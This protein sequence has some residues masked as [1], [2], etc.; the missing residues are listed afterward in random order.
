MFG[1][2]WRIATYGVIVLPL[3]QSA[4]GSLVF[5]VAIYKGTCQLNQLYMF[6]PFVLGLSLLLRYMW[7]C[8]L[9][10][11]LMFRRLVWAQSQAWHWVVESTF[12]S[13]KYYSVPKRLIHWLPIIN[14]RHPFGLFHIYICLRVVAC[15]N[16]FT[17]T[18]PHVYTAPGGP[19]TGTLNTSLL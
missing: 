15:I 16:T 5:S 12:L 7:K 4:A 10:S 8:G 18:A 13:F 3:V 17:T 11:S 1:D 9:S 14:K 19:L 2:L 6:S